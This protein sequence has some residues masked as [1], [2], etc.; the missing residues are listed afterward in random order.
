MPRLEAIG[1]HAPHGSDWG[2]RSLPAFCRPIA[3]AVAEA[4]L[5]D[6]D[7]TGR[8]VPPSDAVLDH[9]VDTLD[10]WLGHGSTDLS[11]GFVALCLAMETLPLAIIGKPT[12][13]TR[14]SLAD[15]VHYLEALEGHRSGLFAMLAV[16]FKVPLCV[17]VFEQGDGLLETGFD[18][19][20][21]SDRRKLPTAT[22]GVAR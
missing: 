16:A 20:T 18:R 12:R 10:R 3:R 8:L 6:D 13:C 21:L 2:K 17:P 19:P 15:R 5:C 7:G 1:R 14:L 22:G 11:R 4:F 9:C